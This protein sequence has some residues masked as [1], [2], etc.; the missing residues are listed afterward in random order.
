[1]Y[2]YVCFIKKKNK[3]HGW[4]LEW[5][6]GGGGGVRGISASL[7]GSVGCASN[8]WYGG[9]G[10]IPAGSSNILPYEIFSTV[11]LSC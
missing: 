10:S 5:G 7:S 3:K 9:T 6:V 1:M 8:W 11:I 4:G 2:M